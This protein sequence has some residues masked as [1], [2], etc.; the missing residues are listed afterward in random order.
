MP[1]Y[2]LCPVRPFSDIDIQLAPNVVPEEDSYEKPAACPLAVD[3]QEAEDAVQGV[4]DIEAATGDVS[5]RVKALPT[6]K[7]PSP[8]IVAHHS[9][10]HF[11]YRSWCP[12]CVAGRKRSRRRMCC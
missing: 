7:M 5:V 2:H 3:V 9:L 12:L 1:I 4:K 11:P 10:T 6:P 8:A